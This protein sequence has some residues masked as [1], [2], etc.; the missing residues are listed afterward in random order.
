M[1]LR[2]CPVLVAF[3]TVAVSFSVMAAR[4]TDADLVFSALAAEVTTDNQA[5]INQK[6]EGSRARLAEKMRGNSAEQVGGVI[7]FARG[8]D[9]K[10][11]AQFSSSYRLEVTRAEAKVAV[12]DEGRVH[13]TSFGSQSLLLLDGP[14]DERLEK[15]VGRQR[16]MFLAAAQA[17]DTDEAGLREA[18]YSHDIRFYKVEVVGAASSFDRVAKG[19]EAAAVF[20]DQTNARVHQL[21]SEREAMARM[22]PA[23]SPVI[24]GRPFSAGPP[25]GLV[26]SERSMILNGPPMA[27]P[28][29]PAQQPKSQQR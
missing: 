15:L 19:S 10:E 25:P 4:P 3:A 8:L 27:P 9:S 14:L 26:V 23:G 6:V 20:V 22:R 16:G 28:D 11:V 18:A 21:A 12:G 7:V 5:V 17:D 1:K 24:K 13:T 2:T 29:P